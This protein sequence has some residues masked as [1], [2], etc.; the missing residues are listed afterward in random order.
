MVLGF[1]DNLDVVG[2]SR[3]VRPWIKMESSTEME[4][5]TD[6]G[7]SSESVGRCRFG[8]GLCGPKEGL[9]ESKVCRQRA[10]GRDA[11]LI[12]S[13]HLSMES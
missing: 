3:G 1:G 5:D 7:G 10:G 8:K 12:L 11:L 2:V 4:V 9:K 13:R 6:E